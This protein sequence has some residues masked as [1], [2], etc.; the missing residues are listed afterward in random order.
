[1][2]SEL[3]IALLWESGPLTGSLAINAG[4][5]VSSRLVTGAGSGAVA[6]FQVASHGAIRLEVA[7]AHPITTPGAQAAIV[8]VRTDRHAFSFFARDVTAAFPIII[9]EY[10]VAVTLASDTRAYAELAQAVH[11]CQTASGSAT[12]QAEADYQTAAARTRDLHCQ[13]MLGVGRDAR[14]FMLLDP[15][16]D[17]SNPT[18]QTW[19]HNV[20]CHHPDYGDK[21]LSYSY[22]AGR[23]IGCTRQT[24]RRLD[25]GVLPIVRTMV[26]DGPIHY[27]ITS[28]ATLEDGPVSPERVQGSHFLVGA[29]ANKYS[30]EIRARRTQIR[31][32]EETREQVVLCVRIEAENIAAS[33]CYAWFKAPSLNN[34]QQHD[35]QTGFSHTPCGDI[36]CYSRFAGQPLASLGCNILLQPGQRAVMEFFLPH[37]PLSPER[38]AHLAQI[39][40]AQHLA[41]SR[42]YW[43]AKLAAAAAVSL[44]ERRVNEMLHA[45]L[46]HLDLHAYGQ[47]PD[48]TLAPEIGLYYGPIGTESAPIIQ[49][50]DSMGCHST[51]ERMLQ[52]FLDMQNEDGSMTNFN[53]YKIETGAA[54][55]SMGEH[56]R[57]T[58]DTAWVRRT[59]PQMNKACEHLIAW[60]ACNKTEEMRAIGCYGLIEGQCA[61][62]DFPL[63]SYMLN[64]YAYLGLQRA[65]EMMRVVDPH[66]ADELAR[67]AEAWKA[68]IRQS[69][70]D[71]MAI[72]PVLP[73]AD[74]AWCPTAPPWP[75][76]TLGPVAL[77]AT[78]GDQYSHGLFFVNDSLLGPLYLVFCEVLDP[79]EEAATFLLKSHQ[80]LCTLEN[81]AYSQPYYS[82]HD[83]AHLMRGEVQQYL[84]TYYHAFSAL[85]DRETYSFW[86]H[87]MHACPHKT[88]EEAWFLMQ[89]RWMLYHEEGDTL[90]LLPAV[91]R[92]WLAEGQN[93]ALERMCSYFGPF[94]LCVESEQGEMRAKITC[95]SAR[96][97]ARV[98]LRLP[99]PAGASPCAVEGGSYQP[100]NESVVI[101]DFTGQ[102]EILLRF[103]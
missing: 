31:A 94:T 19:L 37:Y 16:P 29:V 93:I 67:E 21:P 11:G 57:Y 25:D 59:A 54:L 23:G 34:T 53:D 42:A 72:A 61:D 92:A 56:Y 35:A 103:V 100:D 88:H 60:R 76:H 82:R 2:S 4:E 9:P 77:G 18:I 33:P 69:L 15:G 87:L 80:Q 43:R 98:T 101:D 99:H 30:D 27:H 3:A 91:P 97:P 47:E 84:Q 26:D 62:P 17:V 46:L 63:H 10:G 79:G 51:A 38:A 20:E 64:G 12:I 90:H 24:T 44:P 85:A 83:H 74:G 50:M 102:A 68:D 1:M 70:F 28:F 78:G 13:T 58:R 66:R 86:E 49:F 73:L 8:S 71:A 7:I 22:S 96:K 5:I 75:E 14:V 32:A 89:T 45:G 36:Y 39:D 40:F 55:W 81:V 95:D 52:F 48:G 41:A 65:A 6:A